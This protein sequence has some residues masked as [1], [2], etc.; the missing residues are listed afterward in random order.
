M[1]SP[2]SLHLWS[3]MAEMTNTIPFIF[4]MGCNDVAFF[5]NKASLN[6][7]LTFVKSSGKTLRFM[8]MV[9]QT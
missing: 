1:V 9:P 5:M 6:N 3:W 4:P 2:P 7:N 8:S